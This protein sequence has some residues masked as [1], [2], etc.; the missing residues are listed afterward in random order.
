MVCVYAFE[1]GER[2]GN[3]VYCVL[4]LW[5]LVAFE[6]NDVCIYVNI[7]PEDTIYNYFGYIKYNFL[8]K[9]Y[10]VLL[11]HILLKHIHRVKNVQC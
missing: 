8:L 3:Y 2:V 10:K 4:R 6:F 11:K 9:L 1:Y 5:T 7:F